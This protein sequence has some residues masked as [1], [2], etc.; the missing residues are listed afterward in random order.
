MS[1]SINS[2]LTTQKRRMLWTCYGLGEHLLGDQSPA[3][4]TAQEEGKVPPSPKRRWRDLEHRERHEWLS[5][6]HSSGYFCAVSN[7]RNVLV[8]NLGPHG[9]ESSKILLDQIWAENRSIVCLQDLRI[10]LYSCVRNIRAEDVR[11]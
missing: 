2:W 11:G 6:L 10:P 4:S 7:L 3:V 1:G 9:Y 8:W 5:L